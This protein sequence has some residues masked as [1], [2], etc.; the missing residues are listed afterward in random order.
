MAWQRKTEKRQEAVSKREAEKS[1]EAVPKRETEK[2]Q[3]AVSRRETV[4]KQ[5]N[6][7]RR[8]A[9]YVLFQTDAEGASF[10]TCRMAGSLK[11]SRNRWKTC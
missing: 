1:Q 11:A 3:E 7:S 5:E 2:G 9:A 10:W 8:K 4:K 6:A